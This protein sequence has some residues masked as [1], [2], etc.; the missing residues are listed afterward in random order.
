LVAAIFVTGC[1]GSDDESSTATAENGRVEAIRKKAEGLEQA[2]QARP[3]DANSWLELA[4]TEYRAATSSPDY[5]EASGFFEKGA[6]DELE[7]ATRAWERYLA[8][9]QKGNAED[10][11]NMVYAYG[12]LI[13]DGGAPDTK[14]LLGQAARSQRIVVSERPNITSFFNL[15]TMEFLLNRKGAAER[16]ASDALGRVRKKEQIRIVTGQIEDIRKRAREIDHDAKDVDQQI[17]QALEEARDF[18]LNPFEF[19]PAGAAANQ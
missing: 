8:L 6:I 4:R 3:N 10:A 2:V 16:A 1:G 11:S 19:T 15:A 9:D 5:D 14:R 17:A 7:R 13:L 18:G 12:A